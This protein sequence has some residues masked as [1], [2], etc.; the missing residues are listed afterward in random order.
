MSKFVI[1]YRCSLLLLSQ[2]AVENQCVLH[3]TTFIPY[4]NVMCIFKN[5]FDVNELSFG[6]S[7]VVN[8]TIISICNIDIEYLDSLS[9]SGKSCFSICMLVLQNWISLFD[10]RQIRY[11]LYKI[12]IFNANKFFQSWMFAVNVCLRNI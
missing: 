10:P 4:N 8:Q 6:R 5:M 3:I 1:L 7:R 2:N 11:M 12:V 9:C